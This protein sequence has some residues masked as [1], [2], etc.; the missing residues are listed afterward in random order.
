MTNN[1][2]YTLPE[3]PYAY[4][5]LEPVV[6]ARTMELHHGTHH[7]AYVKKANQLS[8]DLLMLPGDQDPTALLRSLAFN[9]S[10][11]QLH[12]LFWEGMRPPTGAGP[13]ARTIQDIEQFFGSVD[14]LKERITAALVNLSGSGWSV[15][16][17]EPIARRLLVTQIHDHQHDQIS[18]S[19]PIL[20]VDGWEH[21]FY[22]Q[23]EAGKAKWATEF[24]KVCDW[25]KLGERLHSL[26]F[27]ETFVD[28]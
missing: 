24:W 8:E 6:S 28:V 10:G 22:L 5:A 9:V 13:T 16:V 4:D 17:W 19:T 12:S 14:L 26:A 25:E 21:A 18:G 11:H 27:P 7:S 23:Y 2:T 3:L 1:S 15:L 20:V